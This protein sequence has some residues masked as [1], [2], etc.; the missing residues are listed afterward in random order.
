MKEEYK[1]IL[2]C[3]CGSRMFWYNK[4]NPAALFLDIREESGICC[5]GRVFNVCPDK[6]EDCTKLSF[7]D[8]S[9]KLVVF[10]PPHLLYAGENSWMKQKYGKLPR[11]W[12]QF[13]NE[14][15]HEC[16]RVLDDYGVLIFKW[17]ETNIKIS[18]ILE[19]IQDYEP[20]FGHFTNKNHNT[21]WMTFMKFPK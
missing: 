20:L 9:F 6:I 1:P 19:H 18:S 21:V 10:D 16:M 8:K 17:N 5:D 7:P 12:G 13:I 14:S 3:C 11:N 4:T 15:I 2:D